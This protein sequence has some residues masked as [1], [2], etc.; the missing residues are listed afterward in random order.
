MADPDHCLL[1]RIPRLDAGQWQSLAAQLGSPLALTRLSPVEL[2]ACGLSPAAI[3]SLAHFDPARHSADLLALQRSRIELLAAD[4]PAYPPSLK[5][6]PGAPPVLFVRGRSDTLLMPQLAMVGSR[7]P[8]ANGLR[9]ARDLAF[10]F[11]SVG[12]AI[13]SGLA[14]GIDAACH[15]G[16]LAALG[17]TIAVCG[18]GLDR[19]YPEAHVALAEEVAAMGA[20]V[21]EFPPGT[22]PLP[23]HFVQRNRLISG[24]SLGV[25]VIEAAAQSGSLSTARHAGEQGREVFAVPGSIHSPQSRGCHQ[26]LRQGATLV[27]NADDVLRELANFQPNQYVMNHSDAAENGRGGGGRLDNPAEILLDAL[28][29]EPTSLDALT[30]STGL[31]SSSVAS[32]L[33]ALE[34]QGRVASDSA[35]RFFRIP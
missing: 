11:A 1:A 15:G 6:I 22:P 3:R 16:A 19:V 18:T 34:A 2:A 9:T 27:E 28:G 14:L 21:S 12:L 23:H 17:R 26:L 33:I 4:E 29:F 8:T 13:T 10:H 7:H 35:G 25:L 32:L 20:L 30:A 31:S 24:L 5:T